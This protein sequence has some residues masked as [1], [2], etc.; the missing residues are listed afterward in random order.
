MDQPGLA[1]SDHQQ[2]LRGL[3]RINRLT[4]TDAAIWTALRPFLPGSEGPLLRLLD[5]A[6]GSGDLAVSLARRAAA[7]RIPLTITGCDISD[8][9][10]AMAQN[11]AAELQSCKFLTLDVLADDL[12]G[13][14]I[15]VCTLFLHHLEERDAISLLHRMAA[16]A[17]R[18]I[19]IDDL[20]RTWLGYGMAWLGT[21]LLSR[22]QIVHIDG[23]LS[24]QGA[25]TDSEAVA[26]AQQ[27]GLTG[28]TVRRHWPQRFQLVWS[29]S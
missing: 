11:R 13:C 26:L 1:V 19:I 22:S 20:R 28:A 8:T 25:F 15:A 3:R 6:C 21:R 17:S 16:T 24:V 18:A 23:P 12:P 9:A 2:A 10:T 14:D 7:A 27:A 29:R 5:V 4:H